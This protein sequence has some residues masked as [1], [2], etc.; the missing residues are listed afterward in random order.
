M[1]DNKLRDNRIV[2]VLER[3][4]KDRLYHQ[5]DEFKVI[6]NCTFQD[7]ELGKFLKPSV[8]EVSE[9]VKENNENYNHHNEVRLSCNICHEYKYRHDLNGYIPECRPLKYYHYYHV[10]CLEN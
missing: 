10:D 3:L 8:K 1:L 5:F 9:F 7:Y 6:Y 2:F 4:D